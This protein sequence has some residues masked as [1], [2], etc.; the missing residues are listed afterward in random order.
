MPKPATDRGCTAMEK[1]RIVAMLRKQMAISRAYYNHEGPISAL[2]HTFHASTRTV[3]VAIEHDAEYWK[4]KLDKLGTTTGRRGAAG[5]VPPEF[6]IATI[7]PASSSAGVAAHLVVVEGG[8]GPHRAEGPL[9]VAMEWLGKDGWTPALQL[10][11]PG[12]WP[13]RVMLWR[14]VGK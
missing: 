4:S 13:L 7:T 14:P 8:P 3:Q 1:K 2:A 6:I 9:T 5:F 10:S 11:T 12:E